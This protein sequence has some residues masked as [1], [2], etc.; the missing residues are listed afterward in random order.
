MV[1]QICQKQ[2]ATFKFIEVHDNQST[3]VHLCFACAQEKGLTVKA[4][5]KKGWGAEMLAKLVDDVAKTDDDRVGPVQCGECGT[6]YSAFKES[7]RLGCPECYRTFEA[8]LRP[9]LRRIHGS[10]RHV[11]KH[12]AQDEATI[13]RIREMRKLEDELA[14]AIEGED[15]E[16]AAELRDRIL[17]IQAARRSEPPRSEDGGR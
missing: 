3:E 11:G 2:P 1:C 17:A 8:K 9:L 4:T 13:V 12:P 5:S 14:T 16:R 7:G 15:F 6:R 10:P